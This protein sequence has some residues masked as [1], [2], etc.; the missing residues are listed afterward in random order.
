MKN[1]AQ[2]VDILGGNMINLVISTKALVLNYQIKL[3][4]VAP[5]Y[6]NEKVGTEV[7]TTC[8]HSVLTQS[9]FGTLSS[10]RLESRAAEMYEREPVKSKTKE[11]T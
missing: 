9:R 1:D 2:Y 5:K 10:L 11:A 7:T 3:L 4:K 8:V 6:P